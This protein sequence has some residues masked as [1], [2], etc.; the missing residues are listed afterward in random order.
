[1]DPEWAAPA[2]AAAVKAVVRLLYGSCAGRVAVWTALASLSSTGQRASNLRVPITLRQSVGDDAGVVWCG[3]L[4]QMVVVCAVQITP[5]KKVV[6][7]VQSG[8]FG[9]FSGGCRSGSLAVWGL[10]DPSE[11]SCYRRYL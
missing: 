4:T 10:T 6:C 7:A 9:D 2:A 5:D 11:S 3:S 8:H 1:M